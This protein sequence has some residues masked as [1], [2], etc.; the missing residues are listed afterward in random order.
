MRKRNLIELAISAVVIALA[1]LYALITAPRRNLD[2]FLREVATVEIGKTKLEDWRRQVERGHISN[3]TLKFIQG[4][5]V[6]GW[7]GENK[8]LRKLRLGP[9]TIVGASVGFK[10]GIAS[11]ISIIVEVGNDKFDPPYDTGVVVRQHVGF[12]S[13]CQPLHF[14]VRRGIRPQAGWAKV[15]MDPCASPQ[16]RARALAVNTSCLTRIGGCKTV[17]SILPQVFAHP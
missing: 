9:E 11:E 5:W 15:A 10:D 3:V 1:V 8:L 16:D 17:E 2:R 7:S 12:P 4:Q 14:D 13:A 6:I